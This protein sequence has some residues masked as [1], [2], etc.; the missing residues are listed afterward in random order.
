[1]HGGA[2]VMERARMS[3]ELEARSRAAL[4]A[5]LSRGGAIL[6]SGGLALDAVETTAAYLE[7]D[8]LFNAGRGAVFTA[9]GR[10]ELDA[11]IMD[12][13]ARAAGAV[14][15][16]NRIKNPIRAAR[17]IMEH[18]PHVMLIGEGAEA[19]ARSVH[20]EEVDPSYFFTEPR[21]RCLEDALRE[22]SLPIPPR[23]SGVPDAP[24]RRAALD[25]DDHRFGTIGVVAHDAHGNIAVGTSRGGTT[26]KRWGRVGDSP[27]I[28]AGTYA[29]NGA[30]GVSATG[31]GEY[32]IR[33]GA[34]REICMRMQMCGES[35]Q[36]AADAVMAEVGALGGEG[37]VIVL[38]GR[39]R[40][41]F[42]MNTSGMYRGHLESGGE[43][44]AFIFSGS[45][46][47]R[48][49]NWRGGRFIR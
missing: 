23:P 37:G 48:G 46:G 9:E 4:R 47:R 32:F 45:D 20:L 14:A 38:D 13:R 22:M 6:K 29:Q 2:G 17:A 25:R 36:A 11:A 39:G 33:V 30:G 24:R 10:I 5:A 41:A 43:P 18:S 12:G 1:V 42:A 21:W 34:A 44:R 7:D 49:T 35:V 8:D 16:V 28:G 15:G 19:F 26:A 31:S 3:R 40:H 27:L